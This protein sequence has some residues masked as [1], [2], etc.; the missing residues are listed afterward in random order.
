MKYL[1]SCK[2]GQSVEVEPSQAGQ[3]AVCACGEGVIVPTMLQ[4]KALPRVPEK[5]EPPRETRKTVPYKAAVI[6]L[7]SG[8][9]CALLWGI[10]GGCG[11]FWLHPETYVYAFFGI[12]PLLFVLS[13]GLTFAFVLTALALA[14]RDWVKS[15]LAEDTVQRRTFFVLGAALL[16]PSFF[17]ASY[18]YEWQP[19]P[20][21]ATLKRK[22]FVY[23]ARVLPQDSTPIPFEEHRILWMTE[24]AIDQMMPMEL[25]FYFRTLEHPTFSYNFQENYEAVKDTYRIWVTATIIFLILAHLS[26]GASFFMQRQEVIVTGWSGN[27]W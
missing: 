7:A 19:Q 4:I 22:F 2:C 8:I 14:L 1:L 20:Q 16:F 10:I 5:K 13:R 23:G 6:C 15:P 3:T 21:H 25:Y 17:L 27:D 26:M 12:L 11:R 24:E 18:L 9:G